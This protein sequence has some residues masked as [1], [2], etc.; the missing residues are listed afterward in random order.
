[1]KLP[2]ALV[3]LVVWSTVLAGCSDKGGGGDRGRDAE[4][5]DT[6]NGG[7]DGTVPGGN[8]TTGPPDWQPG[9]WWSWTLESPAVLGTFEATTAVLSADAGS[10]HVGSPDPDAAAQ[11]YPFHL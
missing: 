10:Y 4:V 1:M 3:L 9:Q 8:E 7:G 2:H 6:A 5:P 11:I